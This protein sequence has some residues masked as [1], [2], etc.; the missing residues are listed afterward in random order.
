MKNKV[1]IALVVLILLSAT[2]IIIHWVLDNQNADVAD[3][4]LKIEQ[5]KWGL[6]SSEESSRDKTQKTITD[7]E[8]DQEI[9]VPLGL[10]SEDDDYAGYIK[11]AKLE[12]DKITISIVGDGLDYADSEDDF[13][14]MKRGDTFDINLGESFFFET[15]S[16]GAGYQ[17]TLTLE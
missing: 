14:I 9:F 3:L 13:I 11:I 5:V 16:E 6:A 7:M 2:A 1:I 4:E 12:K 15:N 8:L 10:T 17:W